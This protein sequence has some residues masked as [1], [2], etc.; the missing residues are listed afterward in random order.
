MCSQFTAIHPRWP[1][2]RPGLFFKCPL[3]WDSGGGQVCP[4]LNQGLE[5]GQ[6]W[7]ARHVSARAIAPSARGIDGTLDNCRTHGRVW[8]WW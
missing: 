2:A 4:S 7:A 1:H 6:G 5:Q 3:G 8:W